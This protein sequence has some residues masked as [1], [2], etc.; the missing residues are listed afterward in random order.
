MLTAALLLEAAQAEMGTYL[1][2]HFAHLQRPALQRAPLT[3]QHVH[4][5]L[6]AACMRLRSACRKCGSRQQHWLAGLNRR[7]QGAYT[8]PASRKKASA[9]TMLVPTMISSL[10]SP[11][12]SARVGAEKM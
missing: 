1:R 11:L 2:L 10:P 6:H 7:L 12:R 4:K 8:R 3:V 9:C 5:A